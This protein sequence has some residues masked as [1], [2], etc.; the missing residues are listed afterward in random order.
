VNAD[1]SGTLT[2]DTDTLDSVLNSN[3]SDVTGFLQNAGSFG[4]TMSSALNSLGTAAPNGA[5]YLAQQQNS[6]QE[7]ALNTDVTNE[8]TLLATQKTTLT[9]ELNSANQIL[10]SIPSQLNE[11]NE[12]YSATTGYNES[13][14]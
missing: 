12:I 10:Q 7:S 9:N 2:L 8:N 6:A 11:V 4:Q 3:F 14:E 13:T 5:I 1:G